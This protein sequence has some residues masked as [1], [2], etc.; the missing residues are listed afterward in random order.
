MNI[1]QIEMQVVNKIPE[2]PD[3]LKKIITALY[4][5]IVLLG[6]ITFIFGAMVAIEEKKVTEFAFFLSPLIIAVGLA[7]FGV[8]ETL[9]CKYT[10]KRK[11][12]IML[13]NIIVF[14]FSSVVSIVAG[15]LGMIFIL[16]PIVYLLAC[17]GAIYFSIKIYRHTKYR[18]EY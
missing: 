10:K 12:I 11:F 2:V 9:G 3:K 16:I 6:A 17:A 13:L 18:I 1:P 4:G 7:A 15:M 8:I 5:A 14:A